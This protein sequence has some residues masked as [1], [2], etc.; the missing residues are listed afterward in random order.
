MGNTPFQAR[1]G[2]VQISSEVAEKSVFDLPASSAFTYLA[3]PL[4]R[5]PAAILSS[6]PRFARH[7]EQY[8]SFSC[9]SF[10]A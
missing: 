6:P 1:Y 8:K 5:C 2:R 10:D 3:S 7:R 9:R 4:I